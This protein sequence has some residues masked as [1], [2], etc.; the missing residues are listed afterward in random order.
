MSSIIDVPKRRFYDSPYVSG[1]LVRLGS[2]AA[3]VLLLMVAFL[4]YMVITLTKPPILF[5]QSEYQANAN[6]LCPGDHLQ[7]MAQVLV[8]RDP[9]APTVVKTWWN[10]DLNSQVSNPSNTD[11]QVWI[12]Q[13]VFSVDIPADDVVPDAT[14]GNYE[15]RGAIRLSQLYAIAYKVKFSIPEA[16]PVIK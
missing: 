6:V 11:I 5:T 1:F 7:Y 14:P 12:G 4:I 2:I 16:C 15:Q 13:P 3:I 9:V 10:T 8:Y